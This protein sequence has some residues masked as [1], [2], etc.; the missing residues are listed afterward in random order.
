MICSYRRPLAFVFLMAAIPTFAATYYV[1]SQLGIDSSTG[2]SPISNGSDGPWRTVSKVNQV[3]FQPGDVVLFRCGQTWSESLEPSVSGA[4]GRKIR[5]GSQPASCVD[6]PSITGFSNIF[7]DGWSLDTDGS[8]RTVL[9]R[10]LVRNGALL[11]SISNW[12]IWSADSTGR[13]NF[14]TQCVSG[15][16]RCLAASAASSSALVSSTTFQVNAGVSYTVKFSVYSDLAQTV[17]AIVRLDTSPYSTLAPVQNVAGTGSWRDIEYTF[18]SSVNSSFAR[19]DFEVPKGSVAYL[20]GVSVKTQ[21]TVAAPLILT[22]GSVPLE[23]AHHPNRGI[24]P[25]KP[26]SMFLGTATASPAVYGANSRWGAKTINLGTLALPAGVSLSAGLGITIRNNMW[27]LSTHTV[28]SV[29]GDQRSLT[30]DTQTPYPISYVGMGYFFTGARWMLDANGEWFYDTQQQQL[31]VRMWDGQ[32]PGDRIR[33]ASLDAGIK[34]TGRANIVVENLAVSGVTEGVLASNSS[35]IELRR[36]DIQSV[37]ANAVVAITSTDLQIDTSKVNST[38]RVAVLGW[39]SIGMAVTNSEFRNIGV[40]VVGN[41]RHGIPKPMETALIVGKAA[42][43]R[44]NTLGNL[45]YGGINMTAGSVVSD[46]SLTNMCLTLNDCGGIMLDENAV[47][48]TVTGNLLLNGQG[49]LDGL[50]SIYYTHSVGIYAD[51]HANQISFSGNSI[52]DFDFGMQVHDGSQLTID[53]NNFF[54]NRRYQLWVQE[55]AKKYRSTGDIYGVNVS[56]NRFFP[57]NP[58]A[59]IRVSSVVDEDLSDMVQFAGNSYAT[60]FTKNAVLQT[61]RTTS[62]SL[63]LPQWQ[64]LMTPSGG[65]RNNDATGKIGAPIPGFSLGAVQAQ[66]LPNGGFLQN[67]MGWSRWNSGP[68]PPLFAVE[69][70]ENPASLCLKLTSAGSLS[71]ISSPTFSI[72]KDRY[73]RYSFDALASVDGLQLRSMVRRA[74][75]SSYVSLDGD[76]KINTVGTAWSRMSVVF[77]ASADGIKSV[78]LNDQGARLDFLDVPIGSTVWI[79]NP[80]VTLLDTDPNLLGIASFLSNATSAAAF[81]NC[82]DLGTAF[83]YRCASYFSFPDQARLNWPLVIQPRQSVTVFVQNTQLPDSDVDGIPDS[84]DACPLTAA[85]AAVNSRGCA[86]SQP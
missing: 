64:A 2:L 86:L 7:A 38:G 76:G 78:A 34:L 11:D 54:G 33:V 69:T 22:D 51:N 53:G 42:V 24:D 47:G 23:P 60:L 63:T 41:K 48:S 71:N 35:G 15:T 59:V 4:V 40:H 21:T 52:F 70:C 12:R 43:V 50:P 84:Q 65:P 37:L 49:N 18:A 19:L 8:W 85:A 62:T 44:G 10:N 57:T 36:L 5:F 72:L 13:L 29:S 45:G 61:T 28:Q 82:P 68:V 31:N 46:N 81:V 25:A 75:P 1:D 74:G 26:D 3:A 77:K 67:A 14:P 66:I 56:G 30:L 27:T 9:P 32:S 73:Y 79:R 17:K 58:S 80:E 55:T 16:Q 83:A 20:R 6:K 39:N